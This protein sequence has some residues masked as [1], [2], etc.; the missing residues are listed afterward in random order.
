MSTEKLEQKGERKKERKKGEKEGGG[1][2]FYATSACGVNVKYIFI[3]RKC[4]S[5]YNIM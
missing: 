5:G 4:A 1:W 2:Y 3:L